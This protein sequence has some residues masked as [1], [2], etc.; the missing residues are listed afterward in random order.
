MSSNAPANCGDDAA[1]AVLPEGEDW[2]L[3]RLVLPGG[4]LDEEGACLRR[5]MVRELIGADEERLSDR[6]YRT[7]A[8][9]VTDFLRHVIVSVEGLQRAVD[10]DLVTDMLAGDRDYLLL[11]LRQLTLGDL[12]QQ[13]LRCPSTACGEKVDVEFRISELAVKRADSVQLRYP[14]TLSEPALQGDETSNRGELRLPTGRDQQAIAELAAVNPGRANTRLFSRVVLRLGRTSPL[15]EELVRALPLVA[16][17]RDRRADR[18][19]GT[20]T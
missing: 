7:G 2:S 12:V 1:A 6:R 14:F 3:G 11:R 9:Q 4:I 19:A 15:D 16:P 17:P 8:E 10:Q 13:V 18:A 20:R 5:V